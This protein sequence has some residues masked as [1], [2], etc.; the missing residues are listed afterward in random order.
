MP[1]LRNVDDKLVFDEK[2][3]KQLERESNQVSEVLKAIRDMRLHP[4]AEVPMRRA[5]PVFWRVWI[6]FAIG[7]LTLAGCFHLVSKLVNGDSQPDPYIIYTKALVYIAF[8]GTYLS[9]MAAQLARLLGGEQITQDGYRARV[10]HD[11]ANAMMLSGFSE[12]TLKQAAAQVKR[13]IDQ[14]GD[15]RTFMLTLL[16]GVAALMLA[17]LTGVGVPSNSQLYEIAIGVGALAA[18]LVVFGHFS[19]FRPLPRLRYCLSII[20]IAQ[21]IEPQTPAISPTSQ[22]DA[23]Q[24][25][26]LGKLKRAWELLIKVDRWLAG[27]R[28]ANEKPESE[29][30]PVISIKTE[31]P[32]PSQQVERRTRQGT[33]SR[34]SLAIT[35]MKDREN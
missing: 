20:E 23:T 33:S 1:T 7:A 4:T 12:R 15:I 25:T 13:N 28:R 17:I 3:L 8:I 29:T 6:S 32:Q 16:G 34:D 9:Y 18:P 26:L 24:C 14:L 30:L 22:P 5:V 2:T 31:A 27:R 10:K 21:N 11:H 19:A 35:T